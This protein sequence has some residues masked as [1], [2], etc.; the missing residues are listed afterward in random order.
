MYSVHVRSANS[1][2]VSLSTILTL[3]KRVDRVAGRTTTMLGMERLCGMSLAHRM[4]KSTEVPR[5]IV[6]PG[7]SVFA[8]DCSQ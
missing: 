3:F 2:E 4:S 1:E 8:A 7:V 6:P 5:V